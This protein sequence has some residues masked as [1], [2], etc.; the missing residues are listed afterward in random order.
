MQYVNCDLLL[1]GDRN[2]QI[3]QMDIPVAEVV[4]LRHIHGEDSVINIIGTRKDT[5]SLPQ[6]REVLLAKYGDANPQRPKLIDAMFTNIHMQG[7]AKL[8]DIVRGASDG[9][10]SGPRRGAA[11]TV[12]AG[13]IPDEPSDDPGDE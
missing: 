10:P 12:A 11:K 8:S 1:N 4:L 13:D 6:I 3:P 2:F 5:K 9:E 7:L